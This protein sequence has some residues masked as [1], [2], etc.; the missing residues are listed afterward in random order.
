M[1]NFFYAVAVFKDGHEETFNGRLWMLGGIR[2]EEG[3]ALLTKLKEKEEAGEIVRL[4]V[5]YES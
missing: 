4:R 2:D 3:Y 1:A 5:S